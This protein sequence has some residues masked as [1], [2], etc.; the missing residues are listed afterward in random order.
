VE[1][2][3]AAAVSKPTSLL[4]IGA[5]ALVAWCGKKD[6]FLSRLLEIVFMGRSE[7]RP[8]SFLLKTHMTDI[9]KIA[10]SI[11][12]EEALR[13]QLHCPAP[14]PQSVIS[15]SSRLAASY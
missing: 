10:I 14:I 1:V 8:F 5:L 4:L 7:E 9:P 15:T 2:C 13:N 3:S 6:V 12:A 11:G